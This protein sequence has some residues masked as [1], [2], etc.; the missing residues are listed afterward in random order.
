MSENQKL[1]ELFASKQ[2][3]QCSKHQ[4]YIIPSSVVR[5][6]SREAL[7]KVIMLFSETLYR[8]INCLVE[9][10]EISFVTNEGSLW[11]YTNVGR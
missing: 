4:T 2:K 1:S 11:N 8:N 10:I 6:Y 9:L 3:R 5:E 7:K